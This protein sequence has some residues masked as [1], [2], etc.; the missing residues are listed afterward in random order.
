VDGQELDGSTELQAPDGNQQEEESDRSKVYWAK[1][2]GSDLRQAL[3]DKQQA[4]F[5]TARN[6]GLVS[7]WVI[8]YAAHHGTTPEDL[9][10]LSTQQ[11]GFVGAEAETLRFNLNLARGYTRRQSIMAL[12]ERPAFK[13]MTINSDHKSQATAELSDSIVNALYTRYAAKLDPKVAESDGFVGEGGTHYRWDFQGGDVVTA[14]T[15]EPLP[16]GGTAPKTSKVRSGA[17][18]VTVMYPWSKFHE[19]RNSGELL[20]MTVKETESKWNLIAQYPALEEEILKVPH[21]L[22]IYDF[23]QLFRLEEL[24]FS[25]QDLMVVRHFYHARCPAMTE[26]RYVVM[27]GDVILWDGPCPVKEGLPIAWMKAADWIETN[28]GYCDGWDLLSISQALNQ[29]NSDEMGNYSLFGRQSVAYAKGTNVTENGLTKGSAYEVPPGAEMPKA[30]QLTAIPATLPD[31]KKYLH[32]MLDLMSDQSATNRGDPDANVRSGEMAA[33][34]DSIALRYQSYRQNAVREF[35]IRGAQIILDMINRYGETPFLVEMAGVQNRS[36]VQEF[37]KDDLSGIERVTMDVVSPIMQTVAGRLQMFIQLRDLPPEQQA[38]A[39]EL[40]VSGDTSI[41]SS[42]DRALRQYI[43]RENEDLVTG[44]RPVAV[45]QSDNP[46][47]HWPEHV[48]Q[49]NR[50]MASDNQDA[51]ALK[52]IDDHCNEHTQV[53]LSGSPL[54]CGFLAI[55]TPPA[56]PP[57]PQNEFG[58]PAW[59]FQMLTASGMP[60]DPNAAGGGGGGGSAAKGG[61][62]GAKPGAQADQGAQ[63]QVNDQ[64][65]VAQVHPSGT[66]LPQPSTPPG[67]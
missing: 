61:G 57:N 63:A 16:M 47:M 49:R 25:N 62:G 27:V 21:E 38:A 33:L 52:R 22:D 44:E 34:L 4:Y 32:Q 66:Q 20:W 42:K 28:F 9:R 24:E 60:A 14:T 23:G 3:D 13:A 1:W 45:A 35:R 65:G 53:Y 15:E 48:A 31:L 37:T 17:P 6:R 10:E 56:I 51:E 5:E 2:K 7:L 36:Y 46:F 19:T 55:P 59:Q 67:Q 54:T 50:I 58:N 29:V 41:Y 18:T 43:Q 26:G 12:G 8:G 64:Q 11:I 39:Y 30:I 40:I